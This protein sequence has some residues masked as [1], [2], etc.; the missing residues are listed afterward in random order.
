M[1]NVNI[2]IKINKNGYLPRLPT[3]KNTPDMDVF[4]G[5]GDDENRTRVRK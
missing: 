5:G 4:L 1:L 2:Q 3:E